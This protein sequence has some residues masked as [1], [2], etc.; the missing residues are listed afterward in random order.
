MIILKSPKTPEEFS[1][2]YKLRWEIL[3][4]PWN[5][6]KG[7]EKDDKEK[8]AYHIMAF[9][10][11][12]LK[13]LGV[14]RVHMNNKEEAQIRYMAIKKEYERRGIGRKILNEL[15]NQAKEK[16]K[17]KRI[18]LNARENALGFYEKFDY[19][20]VKKAHILFGKIPHYKM[21]KNL[22]K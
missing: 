8:E 10:D 6:P 18:I 12:A 15:E 2:Y 9:Q 7:S 4:K 20:I 5:Q 13:P 11:N 14:G 22:I 3:R 17:A 1:A 19:K 16:W 21:E